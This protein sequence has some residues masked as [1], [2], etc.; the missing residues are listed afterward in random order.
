M[1]G[2]TVFNAVGKL[3]RIN[4]G[5]QLTKSILIT[6]CSSGIGFDCAKTLQARGWQVF[7]S[8]RD[9][10]DCAQLESMGF[11]SPHLDHADEDTIRA[12]FEYIQAKTGGTLDAVFNNGAFAVPG[13]IE[14]LPT[15]AL[16]DIFETNFFGYHTV[17]R[18]V[19]PIMRAQG[20]GRILQ[21]SSA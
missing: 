2:R 6:G 19:L 16:R 14:D 9:P 3:T 11:D 5:A 20:H 4:A 12:T 15:D 17:T 7:A 8:C 21:C 1:D 10:D 18:H 13:L